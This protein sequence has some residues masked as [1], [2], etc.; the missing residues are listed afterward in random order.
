MNQMKDA[1][2]AWNGFVPGNWQHEVDVRDFIQKN[3]DPYEG[4]WKVPRRKQRHCGSR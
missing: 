4:V 2:A 3:Y 1:A